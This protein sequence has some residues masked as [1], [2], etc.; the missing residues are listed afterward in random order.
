M[1]NDTTE[2]A[3][4]HPIFVKNN[5]CHTRMIGFDTKL[6]NGHEGDEHLVMNKP[7]DPVF[8]LHQGTHFPGHVLKQGDKVHYDCMTRWIDRHE[9]IRKQ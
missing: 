2:Q 7:N 9:E 5:G 6:K 8:F 1:I 4:R 3:G